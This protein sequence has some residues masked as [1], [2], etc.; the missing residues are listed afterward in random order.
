M[1]TGDP[2][3][4]VLQGP[5]N[6]A[7][8]TDPTFLYPL[9]KPRLFKHSQVLH[10]GGQGDIKGFSQLSYRCFSFCQSRQNCATG[11]I[12]KGRK[13]FIQCVRIILNHIVKYI[14]LCGFVKPTPVWFHILLLYKSGEK[15]RERC[16][17]QN[18]P[19]RMQP[20]PAG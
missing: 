2:L 11:R 5:C 13:R 1:V 6:Q 8:A 4:G 7:A 18:T 16:E 10:D 20:A 19:H 17:A 15:N 3:G 14:T 9:D 12:G